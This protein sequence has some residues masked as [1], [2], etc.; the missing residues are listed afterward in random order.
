MKKPTGNGNYQL[1]KKD[2]IN[3]IRKHILYSLLKNFKKERKRLLQKK[4]YQILI[5]II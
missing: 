1:A 3:I 2:Y 5:H 4:R